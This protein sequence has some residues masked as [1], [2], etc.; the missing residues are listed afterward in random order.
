MGLKIIEIPASA[1]EGMNI[2]ILDYAIRNNPDHV[3]VD[4]PNF[5]NPLGSLMPE[6][7]KRNL[8][9]MLARRDIPL[10]EDDVFGDLAF[11][12]NRPSALK[13]YD[14]KGLVLYCSS[15][16]KTLAPGYRIGWISPA[17]S[18][19]GREAKAS[20]YRDCLAD[21]ACRSGV[22]DQWRL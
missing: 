21:A 13:A 1:G 14:R 19:A 7:K 4:V 11:N 2:E 6:E 12:H 22:P 8:V 3:C 10:I 20:S 16:S 17:I 18:P 5:N 9:E 15:F